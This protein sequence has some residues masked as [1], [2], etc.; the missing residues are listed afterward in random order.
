M[1]IN[2]SNTLDKCVG[3]KLQECVYA[4]VY[5]GCVKLSDGVCDSCMMDLCARVYESVLKRPS[6]CSKVKVPLKY[7]VSMCAKVKVS[8]SVYLMVS[9]PL[10][11][12]M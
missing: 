2:L 5:S 8:L 10:S 11:V 12:R 4:C 3:L 7:Y 6:E 9:Y 1:C